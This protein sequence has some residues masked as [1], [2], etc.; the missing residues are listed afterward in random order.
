VLTALRIADFAILESAELSLGPGLTAITGE[1]GA[2]KSILID[3]LAVVLG[4]RAGERAIRH[5]CDT[6]EIEAQFDDVRDAGVLQL[7][8]ELGIASDE[9]TVVLRRV[10]SRTGR[11]R[12]L[13]NGRLVTVQQLRAIAAPLCDLSS[14]HAQ[15]R[16]LDRATHLDLLDRF[17][18]HVELRRRHNELHEGWRRATA[19]LAALQQQQAAQA[20]RLDYLR[21][22]HEELGQLACKPGEYEAARS[23]LQRIQAGD[24]L[25]K[26]VQEASW[27]LGGDDG[28]RDRVARAARS[29]GKLAAVDAALGPLGERADEL[30][31]LAG[32]LA[33]ELDTYGRRLDRD[34]RTALRL[35]DR[36][37]ALQKAFRKYGGTEEALLARQAAVAAELDTAAVAERSQGLEREVARLQTERDALAEELSERRQLVATPLA[38]RV[39]AVVRELGMPAAALRFDLRRVEHGPS[40][41]DQA[42]LQ[43]RANAGEAEGAL[44]T[45][46]S[47]GELSRVLLAVQRA[48]SEGQRD[49]AGVHSP[50]ETGTA[51]CIYDEADAGLS[52][53]TGLVLGR[54]LSEVG[55][56]QQVLC[57]SHLPQVAAAANAHVRVSKGEEG[58]RTRSRLAVLTEDGRLAELAR[59]LGGEGGTALAHARELR[60]RQ[61]R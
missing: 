41:R 2:G 1:T 54:F 20:D 31:A 52:G 4:G 7:L 46:A 12:C 26:G 55:A 32:E 13:V 49:A 21:F 43:L 58:G 50:V 10:L 33:Y 15:H 23:Q 34:E 25:A 18:G 36:V 45:V 19:E 27:L 57:I 28:V 53:T 47:G 29:L 60:E 3:A 11:A 14:Q 24:K 35:A 38:E 9:G 42:E 59:M 6:A 61:R 44:A 17:G 56:R 39:T 5:G 8:S 51:T 22:V 16:L 30:A 48:V 37:D 40:G